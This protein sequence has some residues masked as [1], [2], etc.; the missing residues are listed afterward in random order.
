MPPQ[1]AGQPS[2]HP[3]QV[4]LGLLRA[5]VPEQIESAP[6]SWLRWQVLLPHVLAAAAHTDPAATTDQAAL[7]ITAWLLSQA[8]LAAAAHTAPAA[9]RRGG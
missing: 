1:E 2:R 5:D 4:A 3:L 6:Q 8:V 9:C 7:D